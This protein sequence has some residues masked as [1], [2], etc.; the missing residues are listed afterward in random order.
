MSRS[1][2]STCLGPA[3]RGF[4][5]RFPSCTTMGAARFGCRD[6]PSAWWRLPLHAQRLSLGWDR[7]SFT[8]PG[9]I[10]MWLASDPIATCIVNF[11][12]GLLV[13]AAHAPGIAG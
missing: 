11:P 1:A 5:C 8:W 10:P 2:S 9:R 3:C 4:W 6:S 12:G 7:R 13:A